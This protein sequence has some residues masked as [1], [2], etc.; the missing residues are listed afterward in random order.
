M[1]LHQ[2]ARRRAFTLIELLIVMAIIA[3]LIGLLLPAVQKIRE[4]A[5][6]TKCANNLK[7]IGIAVQQ[8]VSLTNLLPSGGSPNATAISRFP[9]GPNVPNNPSP[10]T[11]I[12]Q[13]WG[14]GY[15][16]LPHLDQQNLWASSPNN[17][18]TPV[19]DAVVLATPLP[20]FSCP[21]RRDPTVINGQFLFDYAGNAGAIAVVSSAPNG[22]IVPNLVT[23]PNP[24]PAL[25]AP[26]PVRVSTM[27]RS[28]SNTL[29]VGEKYVQLGT[30]GTTPGDDV[31]G[32]YVF[33]TGTGSNADYSNVRFGDAGPYRDDPILRAAQDLNFPFGSAHPVSINALFGDGSVRTIRYNN[34]LM[35]I[36]CS[37]LNPTP[38]N[39]DDL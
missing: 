18:Q 31:S 1:L 11:G 25:I 24:P 8:Y 38:V 27:P 39:S 19:S 20:V 17:P 23:N 34:P 2:S 33:S 21:S 3:T 29:I 28:Q 32:Y 22:A 26:P 12:A 14:W 4:T 7:Q 10:L 30:S 15:Q 37:R 5:S 36:I 6:K 16:L 13:N 35:P 9:T